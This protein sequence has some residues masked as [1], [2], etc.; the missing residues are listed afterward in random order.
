MVRF[1]IKVDF[2]NSRVE[3]SPNLYAVK[4]A[5]SDA[6]KPIFVL[7]LNMSPDES[8]YY[9]YSHSNQEIAED[10]PFDE[11]DKFWKGSMDVSLPASGGEKIVEKVVEKIVQVP[12]DRVVEKIVQVE[13]PVE[14]IVEKV[15]YV[16]VPTPAP[17]AAPAPIAPISSGNRP[18]I[19]QP[20]APVAPAPTPAPSSPPADPTKLKRDFDSIKNLINNLDQQFAKGAIPQDAYLQKKNFLAEKMGQI[21]GQLDALGIPYSF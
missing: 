2:L 11:D 7:D 12:V 19:P 1:A 5:G 16:E 8:K 6:D 10:E 18:V 20:A 4:K 15:V 21:M 17:A 3:F 13:V 14:K 9:A